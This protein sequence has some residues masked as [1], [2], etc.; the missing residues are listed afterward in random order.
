M[1]VNHYRI[2]DVTVQIAASSCALA[3]AIEALLAPFAVA[4][5]PAY[6]CR[7]NIRHG[8]PP[9]A[10]DGLLLV[11]RTVLPGGREIRHFAGEYRRISHIAKLAW[12]RLD[13]QQR[14]GEI[15]IRP[16]E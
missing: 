16:G 14:Q 2:H 12:H 3:D 6:A 13:L 4:D 11:E 5:N 15:V 8:E 1:M 10:D 7:F 9:T